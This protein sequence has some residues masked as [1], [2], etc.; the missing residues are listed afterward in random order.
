MTQKH[1][2]DELYTLYLIVCYQLHFD[3]QDVPAVALQFFT[4]GYK[5][6]FFSSKTQAHKQGQ[7]KV[8]SRFHK[9]LKPRFCRST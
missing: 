6:F 2:N 1:A 9:R 8:K 3:N 5:T 7:K 4:L